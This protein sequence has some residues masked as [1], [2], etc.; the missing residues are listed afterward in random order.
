MTKLEGF[1]M[2]KSIEVRLHRTEYYPE[3]EHPAAGFIPEGRKIIKYSVDHGGLL[4]ELEERFLHHDMGIEANEKGEPEKG[5]MYFYSSDEEFWRRARD[6]VKEQ[7]GEEALDYVEEGRDIKRFGRKV[8][9][10]DIKKYARE[11]GIRVDDEFARRMFKLYKELVKLYH[12]HHGTGY[13][14]E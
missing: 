12:E 1:R 7:L 14:V 13:V 2:R 8:W 9:R 4:E 10:F 11:R 5:E 3:A 6:V